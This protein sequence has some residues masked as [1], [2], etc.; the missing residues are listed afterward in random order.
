VYVLGDLKGNTAKVTPGSNVAVLGLGSIC[1][2]VI[3]HLVGL[4]GGV[5]DYTFHRTGNDGHA[6]GAG[7]LTLQ[8]CNGLEQTELLVSRLLE[9]VLPF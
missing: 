8:Q 5:V 4:T 7:T 3:Q 2:N 6:A 9:A 1:P